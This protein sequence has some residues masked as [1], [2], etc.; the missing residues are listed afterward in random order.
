MDSSS[1]KASEPASSRAIHHPAPWLRLVA[2]VGIFAALQ[3]A[4]GAGQGSPW[5]RWVIHDLT[6]GSAAALIAH[7]WPDVGVQAEGP[8]L[9]AP[10]GGLNVLNGCEG[11]DL[12][13]LLTAAVLAA[14]LAWRWRF[15]GLAIG[16]AFVFVI[17]QARMLL[18]F[19]LYRDHRLWFEWVHG[20]LGP[21]VL[22]ALLV[23]FFLFWMT[24]S[25]SRSA[26]AVLLRTRS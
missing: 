7:F 20:L 22:V 12:A 14:P 19:H 8:Q 2:F 4:Y 23:A 11:T 15:S 1:N 25:T 18:L 26:E 21:L 3:S 5:E 13:F 9:K 17:N 10:G 6:V 16:L 24:L